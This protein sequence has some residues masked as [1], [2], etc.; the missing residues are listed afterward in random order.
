MY[1]LASLQGQCWSIH[2]HHLSS[3]PFLWCFC[4]A[5]LLR[6]PFF[7]LWRPYTMNICS[8]FP[9]RMESNALDKSTNNSVA[10]RI[11]RNPSI[12]FSENHCNIYKDFSR[13]QFGS[14]WQA[15]HKNLSSYISNKY[16][17]LKTPTIGQIK[18][19]NLF[20]SS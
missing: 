11:S 6:Q 13:F 7:F 9:L 15:G 19:I 20:P 16:I 17:F 12:V 4:I 1:L 5:L 18:I 3:E 8:I 14:D 2:C 10:S